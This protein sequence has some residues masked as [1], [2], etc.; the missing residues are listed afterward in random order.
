MA[1]EKLKKKNCKQTLFEFLNVHDAK[2]H[3]I[4]AANSLD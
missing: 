2:T 1:A 4:K 3:L